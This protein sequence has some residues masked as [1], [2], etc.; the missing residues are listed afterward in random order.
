MLQRRAFSHGSRM[1][2][3][4]N[5]GCCEAARRRERRCCGATRRKHLML[6]RRPAGAVTADAAAAATATG[7][8]L[9]RPGAVTADAVAAARTLRRRPGRCSDGR[10]DDGGCCCEDAATAADAPTCGLSDDAAR[11]RRYRGSAEEAA[12]LSAPTSRLHAPY[13]VPFPLQDYHFKVPSLAFV[14]Y[15]ICTPLLSFF[16]EDM[17]PSRLLLLH[18]RLFFKSCPADYSIPRFAIRVNCKLSSSDAAGCAN[19][20]SW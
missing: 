16:T 19:P 4:N 14:L 17:Q 15:P 6:R 8:M 18:S 2:G 10:G 11:Q 20:I 7:T 5:G 1:G 12:D 3:S 9:R 13:S